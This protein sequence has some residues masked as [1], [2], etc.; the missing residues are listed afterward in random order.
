MTFAK[1]AMA[2]G[3][4]DK[5]HLP[6]TRISR[7]YREWAKGGWGA[8]LTGKSIRRTHEHILSA[9]IDNA[10]RKRTGRHTPSRG[11]W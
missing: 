3:L 6:G 8:L 7:V 11:L 2:E 9:E 5:G 10:E 1:A 4:A